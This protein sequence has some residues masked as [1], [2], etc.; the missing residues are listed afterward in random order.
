MN[1]YINHSNF[2]RPLFKLN[3]LCAQPAVI[4]ALFFRYFHIQTTLTLLAGFSYIIHII[5]VNKYNYLH[6]ISCPL[7]V[8]DNGHHVFFS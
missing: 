4:D 5:D 8:P 2:T 7:F 3:R 1:E 6:D